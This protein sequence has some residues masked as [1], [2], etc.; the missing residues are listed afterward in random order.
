MAGLT[1]VVGFTRDRSFYP[2]IAIVVAH[3]YVL[4]AAVGAS[5][6]IVAIETAVACVFLLAAVLGFK[7]SLWW[8][9]A[10]IAGHGVFDFFHHLWIDNPGVPRWWPGFCMTFD[11]AF[12]AW[13]AG[14]QMTRTKTR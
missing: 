14:Q 6:R 4:F 12:A 11:V 1:T 3:Y 8:A 7:T 9:T 13:T 2:V 10:A 5:G